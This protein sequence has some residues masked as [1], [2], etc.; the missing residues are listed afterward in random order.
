MGSDLFAPW[1]IIILVVVLVILFGARRLP[2]AA[3]SL[4]QSMHI[5]RKSVQGLHGDGTDSAAN[6]TGS[7]ATTPSWTPLAAAGNPPPP[8][9]PAPDATQQ[10][11]QDLQRQ[12]QELQ[13]Q[14][15]NGTGQA[16]GAQTSQQ[17]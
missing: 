9:V 2:G 5:F 15:A 10:Q 3:Q 17:I 6:P 12:V 11:L 7:G 4:G 14:T 16:S 8:A 1:H 13:Q